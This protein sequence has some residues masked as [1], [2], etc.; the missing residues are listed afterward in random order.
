[1]DMSKTD[2]IQIGM[3]GVI[4]VLMLVN[5]SGILSSN[6]TNLAAEARQ[7]LVGPSSAAAPNAVNP[8][9]NPGAPSALPPTTTPT[10]PAIDPNT[11]R[12][13]MAFW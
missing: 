6:D 7:E 9:A 5:M 12:T 3:L 13:I 4:I 11:P 8:I 10:A 2:Q 1:M